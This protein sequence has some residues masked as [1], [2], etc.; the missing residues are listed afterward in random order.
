MKKLFPVLVFFTIAVLIFSCSK[1]PVKQKPEINS[2]LQGSINRYNVTTFDSLAIDSFVISFPE[3]GKYEN[4]IR[5]IY[6]GYNFH[7][8]WFDEKGVLE[9]ANSLYGKV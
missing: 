5:K 9:Y 4:D 1:K 7:H 2:D 3:L 6:R 8:I